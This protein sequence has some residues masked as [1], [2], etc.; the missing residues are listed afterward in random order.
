M[1]TLY[2]TSQ[3]SDFK[4]DNYEKVGNVLLKP[5]RLVCGRIVK[6][7]DDS[8]IRELPAANKLKRIAVAIFSSILFIITVPAL[9]VGA[10]CISKSKSYKK[11]AALE[12]SYQKKT[13]N[14]QNPEPVNQEPPLFHSQS[15][16]EE[17]KPAVM[18]PQPADAALEIPPKID[19]PETVNVTPVGLQNHA[20][21]SDQALKDNTKPEA[22]FLQPAD[23]LDQLL[24]TS[25][26]PVSIVVAP[27]LVKAFQAPITIPEKDL[28]MPSERSR[29]PYSSW[30]KAATIG[31]LALLS[32]PIAYYGCANTDFTPVID[33]MKQLFKVTINKESFDT[34]IGPVA[35]VV[36][37]PFLRSGCYVSA[38]SLGSQKIAQGIASLGLK[39]IPKAK[40]LEKKVSEAFQHHLARDMCLILGLIG[41]GLLIEGLESDLNIH[42][43]RLAMNRRVITGDDIPQVTLEDLQTIDST[44]SPTDKYLETLQ[45]MTATGVH[46]MRRMRITP[47]ESYTDWD[48][49]MGMPL[50]R[51]GLKKEPELSW[52]TKFCTENDL[53]KIADDIKNCLTIECL[54]ANTVA[55]LQTVNSTFVASVKFMESPVE[56]TKNYIDNQIIRKTLAWKLYEMAHSIKSFASI[57]FS[58]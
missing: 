46:S 9:I 57:L 41:T 25:S 18:V 7:D 40:S 35:N 37:L 50:Q 12:A 16:P 43:Q 58:K 2:V 32:I 55:F 11:F 15:P 6:V 19:T 22:I 38:M 36:G 14:P 48:L 5:L 51:L 1:L 8:K 20:L 45:L 44:K 21:P 42:L 24:R 49:K 4:P 29:D 10:I 23:V 52:I 13:A 34:K 33:K 47:L 39:F 31:A 28:Q 27:V 26:N 53:N 54:H 3:N 56:N 17:C 30:K